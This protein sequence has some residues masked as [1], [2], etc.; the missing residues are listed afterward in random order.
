MREGGDNP[1]LFEINMK[2]GVDISSISGTYAEQQEVVT[3]IGTRYRVKEVKQVKDGM[4]TYQHIVLDEIDDIPIP[5]VKPKPTFAV[6]DEDFSGKFDGWEE[7][8]AAHKKSLQERIG[9]DLK[10]IKMTASKEFDETLKKFETAVKSYTK[11]KSN[12]NPTKEEIK[13]YYGNKR[14][15]ATAKRNMTAYY[16]RV[17][18]IASDDVMQRILS[19]PK[20]TCDLHSPTFRAHAN[21]GNYEIHMAIGNAKSVYFHELG[22]HLES[23]GAIKKKTRQ[24]LRNRAGGNKPVPYRKICSW[25]DDPQH[26]FKNKFIDPYVGKIY[27]DGYSEVTSMGMQQFTN[28]K[29]MMRFAKRDFDHFSLIH[30]ILT[31]AI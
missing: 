18:E 29:S 19:H 24:W 11:P 1:I 17:E 3:R 13:V 30:G 23:L 15:L 12:L 22:H 5:A 20:V 6:L 7:R 9:V 26:A 28:Y 21:L 8:F 16:D 14:D 2:S 31:G 27:R 4:L 25:S 10:G